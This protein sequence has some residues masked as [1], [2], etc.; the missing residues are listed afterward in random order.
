MRAARFSHL[1]ASA[2]CVLAL[3]ALA[4]VIGATPAPIVQ[5]LGSRSPADALRGCVFVRDRRLLRGPGPVLLKGRVVP[6]VVHVV[7]V[8]DL[9]W[10]ARVELD[11][12]HGVRTLVRE[13]LT[14]D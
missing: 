2:V 5:V 4:F 7:Y 3:L 9:P 10:L 6:R 12:S 11:L 13:A 1:L 14:I 8:A